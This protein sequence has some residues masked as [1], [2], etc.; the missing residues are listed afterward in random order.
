M[1]GCHHRVDGHGFG[2]TPEVGDGQ[3]GQAC[4]GSWGRKESNTTERLN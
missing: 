4:S 1:V 3:R 2:W